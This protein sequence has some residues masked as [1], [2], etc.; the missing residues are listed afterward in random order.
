MRIQVFLLFCFMLNK[1][2]IRPFVLENDFPGLVQTFVLS[3]PNFCEAVMGS[4]MLAFIG[5]AFRFR[6]PQWFGGIKEKQI[7]LL[8][9]AFAAIYV[10]LQEF[11]IHNL[12]GRN[13]YDPYDVLFSIIGLTTAYFLLLRIKP[14]ITT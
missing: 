5:L 12:G 8:S 7:Y 13:T 14:S 9:I 11:K 6:M 3:F 1:F 4:L 2:L 10:I